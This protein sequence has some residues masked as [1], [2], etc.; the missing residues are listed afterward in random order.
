MA[1]FLSA[2]PEQ[3]EAIAC[4]YAKSL[5]PGDVVILDGGMGAGKTQFVKGLARGLELSDPVTSPTYAYLNV[6]GNYLFLTTTVTACLP[7]RTPSG[8]GSPI[9]SGKTASAL[10]NGRNASRRPYRPMP[11]G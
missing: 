4:E 7:R 5:K 11:G 10:S 8:W 3:T 6:Y 2:S 1:I 9:I